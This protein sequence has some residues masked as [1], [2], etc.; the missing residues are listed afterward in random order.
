MSWGVDNPV[1]RK[2]LKQLSA[3]NTIS[4]AVRAEGGQLFAELER[5]Q[6]DAV[7]QRKL[8]HVPPVVVSHTLKALAEM[9][10][11]LI[12]QEPD[13]SAELKAAGFRMLWGALTHKS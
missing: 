8:Q 9:T 5:I 3:S 7:A 12:E 2:A 11:E 6:S 1:P 4:R 10:M 13:R